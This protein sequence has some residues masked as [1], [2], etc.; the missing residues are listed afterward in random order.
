M[1]E[2]TPTPLKSSGHKIQLCD[3]TTGHTVRDVAFC[4]T[5]ERAT[6]IVKLYNSHEHL[7]DTVQMIARDMRRVVE[8]KID[9]DIEIA[10][11]VLINCNTLLTEIG[12]G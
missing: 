8:G 1:V 7:I 3:A 10:Q 4:D 9:I 11:A 5:A 2:H 12:G 6:S